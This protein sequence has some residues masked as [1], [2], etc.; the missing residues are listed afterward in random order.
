MIQAE[1]IDFESRGDAVDE[2]AAALIDSFT[3]EH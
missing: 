2:Q 3:V 1:P